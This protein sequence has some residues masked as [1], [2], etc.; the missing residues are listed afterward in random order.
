ML[1]GFNA[2][3]CLGLTVTLI[4]APH[5][6]KYAIA[7]IKSYPIMG[8][9]FLYLIN[10]SIKGGKVLTMVHF[11]LKK[12]FSRSR[13]WAVRGLEPPLLLSLPIVFNKSREWLRRVLFS[14]FSLP[15]KPLLLVSLCVVPISCFCITGE[16]ADTL[17]D[18]E[19]GSV[20]NQESSLGDMGGAQL[21]SVMMGL[22]EEP[23]FFFFQ[24]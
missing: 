14:F 4:T 21:I 6:D 7:T 23:L 8:K 1:N 18:E 17:K 24:L 16:K 13:R 12:N 9:I 3:M 5:T 15:S 22:R 11:L 2:E 10:K 20:Y 19:Q